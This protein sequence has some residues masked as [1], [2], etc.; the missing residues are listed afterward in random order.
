MSALAAEL[1]A[2]IRASG[3][4]GLDRFMALALGHPRHGYYMTRDPFGLAGDFV[5]A[6]EISQIFG[7]LLGL[8][9]A[10][11]WQALGGPERVA[12]V[13]LGPGRGTLMLDALRAARALPAFEAA[14]AVHLVETS[15]V[16]Q[17]AQAKALE[18]SGKAPLWHPTI[19]S[20][21][22]DRPLIVLANEFFDALPVRQFQ[23]RGGEWRERLVGIGADGALALGLHA[24][25]TPGL[26]LDGPEGAV[27]ETSPIALDIMRKLAGRLAAQGGMMLAIDYGYHRFALGETLQAVRRHEFV[28]V[29]SDP[30]E[31][32]ITAHVDFSSLAIAA[33]RGGAVAHPVLTQATLLERLG[34]RHRAEIL[35]RN[36]EDPAAIDAAVERLVGTGPRAMGMLF[37]ALAVTSPGLPPPPGFDLADPL[38]A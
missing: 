21:P 2:E 11:S 7:E 29:L 10:L 24:A 4:I 23:R 15:P 18:G 13:E 38:L 26:D 3:P 20:L 16:L 37:K 33:R 34:I 8:T 32:D 9:A 36:A 27:F 28:P 5:T 14:I 30:G 25:P 31:A 17:R 22:E 12:L 6:P 35:K 1:L 19:D